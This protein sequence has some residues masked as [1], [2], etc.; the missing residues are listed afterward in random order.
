MY[1]SYL[2]PN[3][4]REEGYVE[5]L[6]RDSLENRR[7]SMY[8]GKER[9]EHVIVGDIALL[10]WDGEIQLDIDVRGNRIWK[11]KGVTKG[12]V[13]VDFSPIF[14]A[15]LGKPSNAST[16]ES[17]VEF[18]APITPIPTQL[19]MSDKWR[20]AFKKGVDNLARVLGG[21]PV[22]T[23]YYNGTDGDRY[24]SGKHTIILRGSF[25]WYT[26]VP[27][28]EGK[29]CNYVNENSDVLYIG[30]VLTAVRVYGRCPI[31]QF[32]CCDG[33]AFSCATGILKTVEGP[34]FN[35]LL[36]PGTGE[37]NHNTIRGMF[38]GQSALSSVP[39]DLF[40]RMPSEIEDL[41]YLF[42][43]PPGRGGSNLRFDAS[44]KTTVDADTGKEH[45]MLG[46]TSYVTSKMIIGEEA[47]GTSWVD[48]GVK[49]VEEEEVQE[50]KK[51]YHGNFYS[52]CGCSGSKY[53]GMF[54][55]RT[56]Q[57]TIPL[58]FGGWNFDDFASGCTELQEMPVLEGVMRGYRD[59]PIDFSYAFS[60]CEALRTSDMSSLS[61]YLSY[62]KRSIVKM[63][64][65]FQGC[66]GIKK[67]DISTS[68]LPRMRLD[69]LDVSGMFAN[70]GVE[71]I[72]TG[73]IREL[74][75]REGQITAVSM[76]YNT[77]LREVTEDFWSSV[78]DSAQYN[79]NRIFG[80][81]E[82]LEK[83]YPFW[84]DHPNISASGAYEGSTKIEGYWDIPEEYRVYSPKS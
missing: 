3:S 24:T 84:E 57:R 15:D 33:K 23:I 67:A 78:Q 35:G 47:T 59:T 83:A 14:G 41:S 28:Q 7:V 9:Y 65:F 31:R 76:F 49:N 52:Y 30:E 5:E 27:N 82:D 44:R 75:H 58:S 29:I 42:F 11:K 43:C 6:K 38:A 18:S 26:C 22:F 77:K 81:C 79:L 71:E 64:G 12:S 16:I 45:P 21:G 50:Y 2:G 74:F 36:N 73:G 48:A 55:N 69:E 17:V 61:F 13:K 32:A 1:Y 72:E 80:A 19:D 68:F 63:Q 54:Q 70:S 25:K 66:K 37:G 60:G 53:S 62:G 40:A 46:P 4:Q 10:G 56:K 51:L 39:G 34:L 8:I 20:I